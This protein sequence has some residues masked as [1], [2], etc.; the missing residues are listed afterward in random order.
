MIAI[1]LGMLFRRNG[2]EIA[3]IAHFS[4]DIGLHVIVPLFV[5]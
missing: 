1:P 5:T 4:A 2:I 3:M